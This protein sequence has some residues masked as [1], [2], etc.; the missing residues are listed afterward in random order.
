MDGRCGAPSLLENSSE[1]LLYRN[2][3]HFPALAN[4]RQARFKILRL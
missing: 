2:P 3:L 1:N 4:L